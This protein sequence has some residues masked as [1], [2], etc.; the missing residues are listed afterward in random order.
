MPRRNR[1]T[2][3]PNTSKIQRELDSWAM[4]PQVL[5]AAEETSRDSSIAHAGRRAAAYR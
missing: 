2:T 4:L 5:G 3:R 1:P